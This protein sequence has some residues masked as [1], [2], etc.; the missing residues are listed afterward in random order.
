MTL[1]SGILMVLCLGGIWGGLIW[2]IVRLLSH[3]KKEEDL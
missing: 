3:Q 1:V 2:S